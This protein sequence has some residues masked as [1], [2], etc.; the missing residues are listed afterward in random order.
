MCRIVGSGR[1]GLF[2]CTPR[3]TTSFKQFNVNGNLRTTSDRDYQPLFFTLNPAMPA[4]QVFWV[5]TNS[6]LFRPYHQT[7][8]IAPEHVESFHPFPLVLD[9]VDLHLKLRTLTS[10]SLRVRG[11]YPD[12]LYKTVFPFN[13]IRRPPPTRKRSLPRRRVESS[14][15]D[16][17]HSQ[18]TDLSRPRAQARTA[19][20]HHQTT[21]T[22]E[23]PLNRSYDREAKPFTPKFRVVSSAR[24]GV[25]RQ[26][27]ELP[28]GSSQPQP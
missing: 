15:H 14:Q 10:A 8:Y 7:C 11:K 1:S 12:F 26:R 16:T 21:R 23:E 18:A 17:A 20:I 13:N 6:L 25:P 27:Q 9:S 5:Y 4:S 28:G 3:F 22:K 24:T 19:D 2:E